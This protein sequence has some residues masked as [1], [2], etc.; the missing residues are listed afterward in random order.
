MMVW[1]LGSLAFFG[2]LWV[3]V[4]WGVDKAQTAESLKADQ[5]EALAR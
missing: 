5:S 2:F 1:T 3:V 4:V